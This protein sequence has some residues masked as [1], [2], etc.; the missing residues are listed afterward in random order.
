MDSEEIYEDWHTITHG[1]DVDATQ[2]YEDY[3]NWVM[4]TETD[5]RKRKAY[6]L[7]YK[8]HKS[9][10]KILSVNGIDV[11]MLGF[12]KFFYDKTGRIGLSFEDCTHPSEQGKYLR[13]N[14]WSG[15]RGESYEVP[16]DWSIDEWTINK[17]YK[18]VY[19]LGIKYE[20]FTEYCRKKSIDTLLDE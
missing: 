2:R 16:E 1:E 19:A 8:K 14:G 9:P 7:Y 18:V 3:I 12:A 17:D 13:Y 4:I 10:P 11:Y 15:I 5:E 20:T 6:E